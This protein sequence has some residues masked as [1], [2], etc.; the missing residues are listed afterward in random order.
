MGA[1]LEIYQGLNLGVSY[2]WSDF[3]Y[4]S[5][6]A[7]T[8]EQNSLGDFIETD[9]DFSGNI[10][11][12][13]PE[14]NVY[15]SLTYSHPIGHHFN[16]FAKT[17]YQGISGLWV[18]DANTSKT[19]AYNLLNGVL[20]MEMKFGKFNMMASGGVNNI[21]NEVYVGFTNT[22]SAEKRFYEAGAPRDYFISVNLGYSF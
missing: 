22:N 8:I 2:T 3:I 21:F 17:S 18:D 14:H 12:S 20:G 9:R 1:Q 7:R 13:I 15:L 6:V 16:V 5:Y 11:P 19:K 4:L 10:V